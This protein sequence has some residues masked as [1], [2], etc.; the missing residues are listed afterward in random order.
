MAF[1]VRSGT[2]K[3]KEGRGLYRYCVLLCIGTAISHRWDFFFFFKILFY[4]VPKWKWIWNVVVQWNH[5]WNE[6]L[7]FAE[8]HWIFSFLEKK[9]FR[10]FESFPFCVYILLLLQALMILISGVAFRI[11]PHQEHFLLLPFTLEFWF[12]PCK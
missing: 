5:S 6:A 9:K 4:D 7:Y 10:K 8:M 11:A 3:S 1:V 2:A 12:T